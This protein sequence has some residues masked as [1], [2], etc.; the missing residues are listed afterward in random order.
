MMTCSTD[1]GQTGLSVVRHNVSVKQS[2]VTVQKVGV[3]LDSSPPPL[4]VRIFHGQ[5]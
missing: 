1:G 4:K 2:T 5:L 3:K